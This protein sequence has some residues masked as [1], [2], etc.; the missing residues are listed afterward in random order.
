[1]MK[2][3]RNGRTLVDKI[4][5]SH[6]VA[7]SATGECLLYVDRHF[8]HDGTSQAFERLYLDG[9]SVRS[10]QGTHGTADHYVPTRGGD[11]GF[12][13]P[14]RKNMV[15]R[16]A[17]DTARFGIES[18]GLGDPRQGI[19]HVVGPELGITLPG[20]LVVCGDS[21]TS[22][23]GALGAFAFGVGAT[24][25]AHVLATQTLWQTRPK[26]M[27]IRVDGAL[28]QGISAK[29]LIL[30]IIATIG[31]NGATGLRGRIR[32]PR[33]RG[34][35]D[36]SAIDGLQH[37][38]RSG[39]ARGSRRA[40]RKDPRLHCR[41]PPMRRPA[42]CGTRRWSTG[43]PSRAMTMPSSIGK[44]SST[45]RACLPTVTWGTSP[46]DAVAVS[47]AVPDPSGDPDVDRR[48]RRLR[49]LTYMDLRPG[50]PITDIAIDRVFIGSCT[51]S[52]IE[53]LRAAAAVLEGKRAI[54]PTLVVPGSGGVKAAAEAEGLDK[55]FIAAGVEWRDPGCSMCVAMNGVDVVPPGERCASTSNRNFAGRQGRGARTHLM[56]PS[57]AA[58][59]AVTGR[60]SDFRTLR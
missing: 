52:R 15:L 25:V 21:H 32:R 38:D 43:E 58:A 54:V 4:W 57:M 27:R 11:L 22:T 48:E 28:G 20:F 60:I 9:L 17:Q 13:D 53:D 30:H 29:D 50:T 19:V 31:A 46:E 36:R 26:T 14:A 41:P 44:S 7:T 45:R 16:L 42:G 56:S 23:H 37:V 12:N 33:D 55:V 51:N 10:P 8:I 34:A 3:P 24:E 49:A 40:R 39:R 6:V 5:D 1:M 2:A 18:H 35:L 59:A 47:A